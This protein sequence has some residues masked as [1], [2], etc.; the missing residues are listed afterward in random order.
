MKIFITIFLIIVIVLSVSFEVDILAVKAL[1]ESFNRALL[2]FGLAKGLNAV[3]SLLQGTELSFAPIG[4]GLNFSVGEILD[5]FNDMVERFSWIM[6]AAT[7]SIG[8]QKIM[9]SLS[10]ALFMQVALMLSVSFSLFLL[11]SKTLRFRSSIT[12]VFKGFLLLLVLRFSA[13]VFTLLLSIMHTNV[14]QSDFTQ[15]SQIVQNTKIELD[16]LNEKNQVLAKEQK[17]D[18]FFSGLSSKYDTVLEKLN[19]AQQLQS[20]EGSIEKASNN[21]ITLITVFIVE[22]VLMPLLYLWFLINTI[23]YIFRLEFDTHLKK[24]LYNEI[25][26]N[27]KV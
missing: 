3:I 7:V 11:W 1:D 12:F 16:T 18:G 27:K 20:L 13:I 5:P 26:L 15:A 10:G 17:E 8:I 22:T 25:N 14:L 24:V 23:K 6:L 4:V 9:L 2:T 19:I 21:I